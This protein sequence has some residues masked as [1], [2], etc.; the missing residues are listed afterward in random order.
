MDITDT[1]V[2]IHAAK[3]FGWVKC[4]RCW[5]YHTG[6]SNF[7]HTIEEIEQNP[8]LKDEH[9]CSKCCDVILE[10]YPNHPSAPYIKQ[11]GI[12]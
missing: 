10:Q 7:G 5:H 9:L 6:V 1:T 2:K 8:K 11:F 3:D 12:V 4:P